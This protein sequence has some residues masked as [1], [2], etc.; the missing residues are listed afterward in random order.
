MSLPEIQL[1]LDRARADLLAARSNLDQGFWGV[2]VSWAYDAMYY[3]S[4]ALLVSKGISRKTHSGVISAFGE[5][6]V[7]T[8]LIEKEYAKLLGQAFDSRLDTDYD[9]VFRV[10]QI[11]ADQ[12]LRDAQRFVDRAES[13]LQQVGAI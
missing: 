7:K 13:Y 1:Y 2:V 12:V 4:N 9:V 11:L 3:A 5:Y 6:F 8:G 10:D